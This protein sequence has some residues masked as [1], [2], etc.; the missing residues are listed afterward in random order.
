MYRHRHTETYNGIRIDVRANTR[1]ELLE[2]VEAKKERINKTNI[3][4]NT[5]LKDFADMYIRTYKAPVVSEKWLQGLFLISDRH[6]VGSLGNRP[7]STIKPLEVQKML[8]S[9]DVSSNYMTKIYNL[10]CQIFRHAYKNGLTVTDYTDGLEKPKGRKAKTGKRL[11]Q[12]EQESMLRVI[13]GHKAETLCAV[14]YYCGL[15][16]GEARN[17][18]WKDVDIE[19]RRI[20]V[21]GT[22]TKNAA[23]IVPIPLPLVDILK[24]KEGKPNENVCIAD[25]QQAERAWRN[26]KRLMNIDMGCEMFRNKLIPPYKVQEDLRLYDLRHTYCTNLELQGVPIS[27]ASRLM[28]HSNIGITANMYTH[29]TSE[30]VAIAEELIDGCGKSVAK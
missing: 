20:M 26:V 3:N 18:L 5:K 4:T 19:A 7:I 14:M 25:K 24:S 8:N 12:K 11:T 21:H 9:L 22:K 29:E 30:A 27:I 15:R 28:G 6:I 1:K 16:T 17:L 13:K 2:K 23:R 10:T